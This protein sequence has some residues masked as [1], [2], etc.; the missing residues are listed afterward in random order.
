MGVVAV[1]AVA[2]AALSTPFAFFVVAIGIVIPGFTIDR[3][4]GGAGILGAMIS[5]A[6]ALVSLGIAFYTY[7][8]CIP[9]RPGWINSGR[10]CSSSSCSVAPESPGGR[11]SA[12]PSMW[13]C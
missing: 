12:R 9:T 8:Y 3:F 11:S 7:L 6:I 1:C 5:A 10:R 4:R 2:F 13:Q